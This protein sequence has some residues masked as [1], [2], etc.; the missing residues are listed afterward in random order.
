MQASLRA[1]R[2]PPVS[3]PASPAVCEAGRRGGRRGG[4]GRQAIASWLLRGSFES[5]G[6]NLGL[7]DNGRS[8]DRTG[9]VH[10]LV[11]SFAIGVGRLGVAFLLAAL[12]CPALPCWLVRVFF[13]IRVKT[14]LG[15]Y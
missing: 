15:N 5:L 4:V 11:F 12:L 6:S 3:Q 1:V 2:A 9:M 8:Q 14:S 13:L 10:T 7:D